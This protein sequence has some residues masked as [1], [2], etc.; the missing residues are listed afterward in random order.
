MPGRQKA[1]ISF[2]LSSRSLSL[3]LSLQDLSLSLSLSLSLALS[4]TRVVLMALMSLRLG[5]FTRP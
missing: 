2:F 4:A 1:E 5:F 3:S